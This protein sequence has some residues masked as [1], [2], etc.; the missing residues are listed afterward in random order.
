MNQ[1]EKYIARVIFKNKI[2]EFDGQSYEDFFTKIMKKGNSGFEKV[3]AHGNIG[4][5]KNDGFDKTKGTY[6]QVFAPG[7]IEKPKTLSDAVSKLEKDFKG[8]FNH[9]NSLCP[10]KKF[11]Y[12][13]NDKYKGCPAPIHQKLLELKKNYVSVEFAV[14]TASDLEDEFLSLCDEDIIDAISFI[15]SLSIESLDYSV[16]NEAIDFIL[17]SEADNNIEVVM[18]V[19]D[20]EEKITFNNLSEQVN[21]WLTNASYSMGDLNRYFMR[22]SKFVKKELRNKF[23]DMYIESTERI[24]TE[25]NDT[26]NQRFLYILEKACYNNK[27]VVRDSVLILMA[28]YFESCD[29]FENPK[30]V[31][32]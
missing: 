1:G 23:N 5:R 27:K 16:L 19:P 21:Q 28:C 11:Y 24:N 31:I 22:N 9:W 29:I 14:F 2:F 13:V 32:E 15:P 25:D 10:I 3:K 20:F 18:D 12:V 8:A 30:E 4:D 17:N 7:D 6:Y 26:N